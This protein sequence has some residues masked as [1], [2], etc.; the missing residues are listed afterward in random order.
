MVHNLRPNDR[1]RPAI[2]KL[3][4]VHMQFKL[5]DLAAVLVYIEA[6]QNQARKLGNTMRNNLDGDV[7]KSYRMSTQFMFQCFLCW[8]AWY[9]WC[10][11][12]CFSM[13][14][15]VFAFHLVY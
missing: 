3:A 8:L 13:R 6:K 14:S 5:Q 10:H 9:Q 2:M 1:M 11:S 12:W 7:T 15:N 4:A